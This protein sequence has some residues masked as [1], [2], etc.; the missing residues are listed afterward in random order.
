MIC[1][2]SIKLLLATLLLCSPLHSKKI[3]LTFVGDI[4]LG[5]DY[6][7]KGKTFDWQWSQLNGTPVQRAQHFFSPEVREILKNDTITVGNF[8]GTTFFENI[9]PNLDKKFVFFGKPEYINVLKWG[10]I[11]L[12]N[13]ANNHAPYDYGRKGFKKTEDTLLAS[14]IQNYG[15]N[16]IHG[17][18][19][20]TSQ[21][22]GRGGVCICG[23]EAFHS[24]KATKKKIDKHIKELHEQC[25]FVVYTFHWGQER[26]YQHNA[27]QEKI[28]HYAIDNG[29]DLVIGHHPHVVQDIED[30]KGKKI[31]YSLGN[32]IF[33]GNRNPSDKEAIMFQVNLSNYNYPYGYDVSCTV[34]PINISSVVY[35]NDYRIVLR[36]E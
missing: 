36:D 9:K 27:F 3:D 6:R 22:I 23:L 4:V 12:V 32:F 19:P 28:A 35:R 11:D 29:A 2:R 16:G 10:G 26:K 5:Q 30:Y 20:D 21:V 25:K 24:F 18:D 34:I 7:F 15:Y 31:V 1:L 14:G 8:E 17:Y 33:G 13:L